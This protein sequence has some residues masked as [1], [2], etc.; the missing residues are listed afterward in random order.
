MA[1]MASLPAKERT[2]LSRLRKDAALLGLDAET[3]A[4]KR[5]P[6]RKLIP[7]PSPAT[8]RKRA[9]RAAKAA[10]SQQ[11]PKQTKEPSM[12]FIGDFFGNSEARARNAA[13]RVLNHKLQ[14]AE[15][16]SKQEIL[17][18][19]ASAEAERGRTI[20][21]Q[22][23]LVDALGREKAREYAQKREQSIDAA[24][25]KVLELTPNK[26]KRAVEEDAK[27][28]SKPSAKRAK[29]TVKKSISFAGK[30]KTELLKVTVDI[31]NSLDYPDMVTLLVACHEKGLL[32]DVSSGTKGKKLSLKVLTAFTDRVIKDSVS[33][34]VIC[35]TFVCART[36]HPLTSLCCDT[37]R[38]PSKPLVSPTS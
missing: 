17:M 9:S 37:S 1:S 21:D 7:N 22:A 18:Q 6:G 16:E 23:R 10:A 19:E 38:K 36:V 13:H 15:R 31:I 4:P 24:Y 14:E 26:K 32:D 2:R 33:Y 28:A 34:M 12:S 30:T 8:L 27:P 25:A 20:A 5:K 3:V 35:W 29:T 11:S